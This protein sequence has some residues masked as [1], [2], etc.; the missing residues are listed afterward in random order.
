[1]DAGYTDGLGFLVPYQG[2]RY[3][4]KE[5]AG[6]NLENSKALFH[7]CHSVARNVIERAFGMLKQRWS[8][9]CTFNIKTKIRIINACFI[10]HNFIGV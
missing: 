7:L 6:N 1:V 8:I 10:L 9:L 3:H 4:Q 2:T 5:W